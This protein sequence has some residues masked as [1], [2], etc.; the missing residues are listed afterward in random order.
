MPAESNTT[1]EID[2]GEIQKKAGPYPLQAFA[3]VQ[4]GLRDTVDSIRANEPDLPE[5]GRHVS[6]QELC[7]GLR[8]YA[9]KQY[10]LLAHTVLER[11][12]IRRTEDFGRIVFA[13]VEA[14]MMHKTDEDSLD[15]FRGVFEF[16]EAFNPLEVG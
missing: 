15:D 12:S 6:G 14:G 8:D 10:G 5:A 11:W 4:E 7:I 3:F 1:M 16:D 9:V 13:L 2:W